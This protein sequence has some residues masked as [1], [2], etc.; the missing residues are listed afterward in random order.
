[1]LDTS[2]NEQLRA[3]RLSHMASDWKSIEREAAQGQESYA[4]LLHKL[5]ELEL[6]AR[7]HNRLKRYQKDSGLSATKTLL[8]LE[9][10]LV[11]GTTPQTIM[12]LV[13]NPSWIERGENL[14]LF[15][16]SG[17]GK[18]HVVSAI[19]HELIKSGIRG[20]F[21]SATALVQQL[22]QAKKQLK[23]NEHLLKLDR[24]AFII[25]DDMGYVSRDAMETS[26]L[27]EFINHRYERQTIMV[28]SNQSFNEW[29]KIFPDQSMTVAAI[30]RLIHHSHI[31]ELQGESH[32]KQH[33]EKREKALYSQ[34]V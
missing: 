24:Y 14:L 15:G 5:C 10:G 22:V 13:E 20:K 7:E 8:S 11:C 23:L 6:D 21:F 32:R 33:A 26:V 28:T 27:F 19:G 9:L 17:L 16:A 30:D 31:I 4:W 2:I 18:T 1:M 29:N 25:I 3:L 34:Y 12:N